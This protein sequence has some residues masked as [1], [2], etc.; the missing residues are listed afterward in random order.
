MNDCNIVN[1][2]SRSNYSNN[3][4]I[5]NKPQIKV[6][7]IFTQFILFVLFFTSELHYGI[8]NI[9]RTTLN[10]ESATALKI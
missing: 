6:F 4:K 7:I 3:A 5:K 2:Y 1:N 10:F 9:L 8:E